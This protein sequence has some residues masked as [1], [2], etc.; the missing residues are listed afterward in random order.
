MLGRINGD[1]LTSDNFKTV[2]F[3]FP[4]MI[5][6]ASQHVRLRPGDIL[7]HCFR[8]FPNAPTRSARSI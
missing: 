3:S 7:T 1:Q 4:Q 8:P 6:R 5:A 2:Y